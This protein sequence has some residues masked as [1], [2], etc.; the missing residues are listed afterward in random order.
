MA[1]LEGVERRTRAQQLPART[2]A[3]FHYTRDET[4][5]VVRLVAKPGPQIPHGQVEMVTAYVFVILRASSCHLSSLTGASARP[6]SYT[7]LTLPTI[8]SV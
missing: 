4:G 1:R 5:L 6:V 2:D 3:R 7:H 8:Y